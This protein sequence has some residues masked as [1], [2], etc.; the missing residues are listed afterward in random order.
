MIDRLPCAFSPVVRFLHVEAEFHYVAVLHHIVLAFD[1]KFAGL[2]RLGF[3]AQR[4][5]LLKRDGLSSDESALEITMDHSGSRRCLVAGADCPR[6]RLLGASC[7]VG[8][9]TEKVINR[10]DE[11]AHSAVRNTETRKEFAGLIRR[12]LGQFAFNL[13]AD[14][15]GL[16][17]KMGGS[18]YSSILGRCEFADC[19]D[20]RIVCLSQLVFSDVAGQNGGLRSEKEKTIEGSSFLVGELRRQGLPARIKVGLDLFAERQFS[21]GKPIAGA[22]ALLQALCAPL[23]S[24][25]VRQDKLCVDHFNVSYGV[26]RTRHMVNIRALKAADNLNDGINFA[27]VAKELVAEPLSLACPLHETC[28]VNEF[29]GGRNDFLRFR[30]RSKLSQALVG[31]VNDAK[32][33]LNRTEGKVCHVS[34]AGT[35]HRIEERGL[36][37]IGQP[38]DTCFEHKAG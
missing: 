1:A 35:G 7:K 9:K 3:G 31:D 30:K 14:D 22:G 18:N 15:N 12:Q 20:V 11:L 10:A 19:A 6:S 21:L 27:D 33:G 38:G 37:D 5:E 28:D 36:A 16:D 17:A 34:F 29:N 26:N 4:H 8:S 24:G 25:Q 13:G 23:N 32:I 2:A